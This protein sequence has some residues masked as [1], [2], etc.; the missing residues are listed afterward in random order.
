MQRECLRG[1]HLVG[2]APR[3]CYDGDPAFI[4]ADCIRHPDDFSPAFFGCFAC[5]Q[6][7]TGGRDATDH[8]YLDSIQII[9]EDITS[10]ELRRYAD[11]ES[12]EFALIHGEISAFYVIPGDYVERGQIQFTSGEINPMDTFTRGS[13]IDK[14]LQLN[15]LLR[16]LLYRTVLFHQR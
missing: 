2:F 4:P 3:S 10:D 1:E 15:L 8:L 16:Y 7:F 12:A 9:P 14:L 6:V 11:I 13:K 5:Q